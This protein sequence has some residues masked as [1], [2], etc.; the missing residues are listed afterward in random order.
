MV[1]FDCTNMIELACCHQIVYP[2]LLCALMPYSIPVHLGLGIST[3]NSFCRLHNV[4]TGVIFV[5]VPFHFMATLKT[6]IM[7]SDV[8][9]FY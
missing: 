9:P 6:N 7:H 4:V 3:S 8:K 1:I 2:E 5:E